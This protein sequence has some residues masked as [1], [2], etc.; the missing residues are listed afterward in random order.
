MNAALWVLDRPDLT[1]NIN[2]ELLGDT[3]AKSE[4]NQ[5]FELQH[6]VVFAKQANKK[7]INKAASVLKALNLVLLKQQQQQKREEIH[8]GTQATAGEPIF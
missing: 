5:I 2:Q 6:R 1:S 8:R 7:T 4:Y 3:A